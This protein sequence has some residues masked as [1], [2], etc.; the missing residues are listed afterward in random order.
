M[1]KLVTLCLIVTLSACGVF[2]KMEGAQTVNGRMQL[3]LGDAW[4]RL[5]LGYGTTQSGQPYEVWTQD[6]IVID[7]LRIWS[8]L[9]ADQ[10]MAATTGQVR[11]VAEQAGKAQIAVFKAGLTSEK[12]VA[13]FEAYYAANRSSVT[14]NK[15]EPATL[16]GH[17]AVRFEFELTH[18][19]TNLVFQ[20]VGWAAN[21]KDQL[22]ALVFTA[23]KLSF[24]ERQLPKV[25]AIAASIKIVN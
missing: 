20:G 4:N 23:P 25:E 21:P 1:K 19:S 17:A 12:L 2:Q 8:A 3:V 6:G 22:F 15:V 13:L 11:T 24:F 10:P 16:S 9:K 7:Q 5:N 14:V 18:S